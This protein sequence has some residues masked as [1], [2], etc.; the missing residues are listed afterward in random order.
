[1]TAGAPVFRTLRRSISRSKQQRQVARFLFLKFL[2][3]CFVWPKIR[4]PIP[5][6]VV[7]SLWLPDFTCLQGCTLPCYRVLI[8]T[9]MCPWL[10]VRP[11]VCYCLARFFRAPVIW[12]NGY[13]RSCWVG[14]ELGL[15]VYSL[16]FILSTMISPHT[17]GACCIRRSCIHLFQRK[18]CHWLCS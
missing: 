10:V 3:D 6:K 15:L 11:Y 13:P 12:R 16:V 1:M 4:S 18:A 9:P 2:L 5:H 7:V 8:A 14:L 17:R